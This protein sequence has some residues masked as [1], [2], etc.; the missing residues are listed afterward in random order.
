VLDLGP[1]R[2]REGD[3]VDLDGVRRSSRLRPGR[4]RDRDA[5]QVRGRGATAAGT[6]RGGVGTAGSLSPE[7]SEAGQIVEPP[8]PAS[9]AGRAERSSPS[10][11][12]LTARSVSFEIA[13]RVSKTPWPT[14][15]QAS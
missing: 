15:A 13:L 6:S 4:R 3:V 10:I 1:W 11:F 2:L 7:S 8:V 12:F 14:T 9:G 5:V